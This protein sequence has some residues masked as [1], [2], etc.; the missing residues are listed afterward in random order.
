M[1][2]SRF[3]LNNYAETDKLAALCR[4]AIGA[5]IVFGYPLTF[6]TA[7]EGV[8]TALKVLHSNFH[9]LV[10]PWTVSSVK[11]SCRL[12]IASCLQLLGVDSTLSCRCSCLSTCGILFEFSMAHKPMRTMCACR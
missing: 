9:A 6:I 12:F 4:V 5:S 8:L 1:S 3:I 2:H 7:R 10:K 11:P